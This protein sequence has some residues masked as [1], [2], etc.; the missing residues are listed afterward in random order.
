[1][2][3]VCGSSHQFASADA[4]PRRRKQLGQHSA[5]TEEEGGRT[6]EFENQNTLSPSSC[7]PKHIVI[8]SFKD[9]FYYA[10]ITFHA[11]QN[12]KAEGEGRCY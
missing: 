10:K 6:F 9:I 12:E 5:V 11:L 3:I 7:L 4:A 1:M 2:D 8:E